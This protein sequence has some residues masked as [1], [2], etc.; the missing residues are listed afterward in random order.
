MRQELRD[1]QVKAGA[2]FEGETIAPSSFGNDREARKAAREGVVLCDRSH[3]GL[4]QLKGS[5]R[6]RFLH[7]Q[8]TNNI[9][10]FKPGQGGDTVFV[11]S[12]GRTLDLAT[13]YVAVDAIFI[14]VSPNRRQSLMQWM[15]RYIF[16][17]D[18]VELTDI[19]ENNAIF[20]LIGKQSDAIVQKMGLDSLVGQP[21]G[22]H[23]LLAMGNNSLLVA[24]GS[25]LALPGYTFIAPMAIAAEVWS[26]LNGADVILMGDRVWEQLRIQQ[27]RPMPD[28]ELTE[29]YNPLEAG[30]W[31]AISFE[32]GCYIGQET[33]ARL[34][35]YQG[36]KQRLWGL[37][38]SH[39]VAEGTPVMLNDE[40]KVGV[41]TS[42]IETE[43]GAFGLAYIRT[44][45]GGAGLR[46]KVAQETGE[47][48]SVPFLTHEYFKP[49]KP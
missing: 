13:V 29:D 14:L 12:T 21:E 2:I 19:S 49:E 15:D 8:T 7:N 6:A 25:N 40:E 46:V 43:E 27:G 22:S 16:P 10:G 18:K 1:L 34:N 32:K 42:C 38:L 31:K 45:A 47:T 9:N 20:T 39:R 35:T 28:K 44:K 3:G 37:K 26:K 33:I 11:N 30:L 23:T 4:L 24:V 5:D 41:V 17:M 48:L 36:V